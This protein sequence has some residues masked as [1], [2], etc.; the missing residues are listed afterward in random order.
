[1]QIVLLQ[2]TLFLQREKVLDAIILHFRFKECGVHANVNIDL[3]TCEH[4]CTSECLTEIIYMKNSE[5]SDPV[6]PEISQTLI[7]IHMLKLNIIVLPVLKL[8]KGQG[9]LVK[10]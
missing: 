8:R 6:Y 5:C 2:E 1:M 10:N 7:I 9:K 4:K 3:W